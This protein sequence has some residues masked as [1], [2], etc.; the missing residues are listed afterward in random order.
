MPE[1]RR[2]RRQAV[3]EDEEKRREDPRRGKKRPQMCRQNAVRRPP[4]L[5]DG[6]GFGR[7]SR[8]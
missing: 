6:A 8:P 3:A 2:M 4:A 5:D 1:P 7:R